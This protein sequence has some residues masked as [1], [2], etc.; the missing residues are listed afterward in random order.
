MCKHLS[1][2]SCF[3]P[4][5]AYPLS[6]TT[7]R[8]GVSFHILA[9][10]SLGSVRRSGIA[11]S[12]GKC[13]YIFVLFQTIAR[14]PPTGL[15]RFALTGI[16]KKI[17]RMLRFNIQDYRKIGA[18]FEV[19]NYVLKAH[20]ASLVPATRPGPECRGGSCSQG[21]CSLSAEICHVCEKRRVVQDTSHV[22]EKQ[23][24]KPSSSLSL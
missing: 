5:L 11:E 14:F 24:W 23:R 12:K 16:F 8:N 10:V 15:C 2:L 21:T 17:F 7:H 6:L 1:V 18:F 3:T 19:I 13:N 22:S 9:N 20:T 4:K